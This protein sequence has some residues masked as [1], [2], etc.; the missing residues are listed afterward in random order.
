MKDEL[1]RIRSNF[2]FSIPYVIFIVIFLILSTTYDLN[3]IAELRAAPSGWPE[4]SGLVK[5]EI[6]RLWIWVIFFSLIIPFSFHYW[7]IKADSTE[8]KLSHALFPFIKAQHSKDEIQAIYP[9]HFNT[10]RVSHGFRRAKYHPHI[11]KW[12]QLPVSRFV[13]T[14]VI[15]IDTIGYLLSLK[16]P[17]LLAKELNEFYNLPDTTPE[18]PEALVKKE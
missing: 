14:L 10:E 9:V 6:I 4:A 5:E 1:Y 18:L 8:I 16:N 15:E 7:R 13:H 12:K 11:K 2:K 17:E 3:H